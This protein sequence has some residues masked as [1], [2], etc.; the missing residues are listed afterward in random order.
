MND[1][2]K[3]F[4]VKPKLFVFLKY[5][6]DQ[7]HW[8][9][10]IRINNQ[11]SRVWQT[12]LHT[13]D[14]RRGAS[15]KTVFERG[16]KRW[17]RNAALQTL[18]FTFSGVHW[19]KWLFLDCLQWKLYCSSRCLL[20]FSKPQLGCHSKPAELVQSTRIVS[21]RTKKYH[22]GFACPILPSIR[23]KSDKRFLNN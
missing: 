8:I 20:L 4:E 16:L 7:T 9:E 11:F 6:V 19:K 15:C 14:D 18:L 13:V 3:L 23:M 17:K 12:W 1:F 21:S 5:T 22:K 2:N 10:L